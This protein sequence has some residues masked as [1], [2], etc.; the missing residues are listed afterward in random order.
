[1]TFF[2]AVATAGIA[3]VIGFI[4][5]VIALGIRWLKN[6]IVS[7]EKK[8]QIPKSIRRK[9]SVSECSAKNK[10]LYL[11]LTNDTIFSILDEEFPM[12]TLEM[13]NF[14]K[15]EIKFFRESIV[16]NEFKF[17]NRLGPK[18]IVV[19]YFMDM[20]LEFYPEDVEVD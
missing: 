3:L 13:P 5:V 6:M 1:M 15:N 14:I 10:E 7:L 2:E 17:S 8:Y 16:S 19:V 4:G 20:V 9:N 12:I 11:Y 18:E